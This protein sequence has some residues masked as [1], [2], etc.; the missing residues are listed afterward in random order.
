[1]KIQDI[2]MK[3]LKIPLNKTFTIATE[4]LDFADNVI[5]EIITD[6][7]IGI[8]EAS[9]ST[10]VLGETPEH[11]VS[12]LE[13]FRKNLINQDASNMNEIIKKLDKIVVRNESSKAAIDFALFDLFGR[14]TKRPVVNLLGSNRFSMITDITIG[15]EDLN[16]TVKDAL[17][18]TKLGFKALKIKVGIDPFYDIER[19][20]AVRENVGNN[21]QIRLDANQGF[22]FTQ[23][24][25][26]IN[27][28]KDL[29]VEFIEQPLPEWDLV[30]ISELR[31][32]SSV[33]I[34][35][36]ESVK[37]IRDFYNALKE[38]AC[39]LINIKLMKTG[40]I[41]KAMSLA[42]FALSQNIDFMVGCMSE[43]SLGISAGMHFALGSG[44]KYIDL[45]CH[46]LQTQ[47]IA[48]TGLRTEN[49]ENFIENRP[50]FGVELID[51]LFE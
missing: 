38:S 36:D 2:K 37:N 1:M 25:W 7:A 50:G 4:S 27:K 16:D 15:I 51:N 8:G 42:D 28:I 3:L 49:G 47:S 41:K 40:G 35:L 30:K 34:M 29:D 10:F 17:S 20:K 44:A 11:V 14:L 33:P 39:D 43:A 31:K 21:I 45:D 6:E 22:N 48:K 5:I 19:I 9:P 32:V 24:R 23:A 46:L 13:L 18:Y 12:T 26:F